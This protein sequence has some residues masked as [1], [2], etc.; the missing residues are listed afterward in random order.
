MQK[1]QAGKEEVDRMLLVQYNNE[2]SDARY[3]SWGD[4]ILPVVAIIQS[5]YIVDDRYAN[6]YPHQYSKAQLNEVHGDIPR[7]WVGG[8]KNVISFPE[9]ANDPL[10]YNY[11][12]EDGLN[13]YDYANQVLSKYIN[14]QTGLFAVEIFGSI[15]RAQ[16]EVEKYY[17]LMHQDY[18]K[19]RGLEDVSF[20]AEALTFD[21]IYRTWQ[22]FPILI[23][24]T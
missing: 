10:F 7:T 8:E 20:E 5:N 24:Q 19:K 16:L 18:N 14:E 1:R 2:R 11:F 13:R 23:D 3:E 17:K 4:A 9:W 12:I 15:E 6:Y 22:K 21:S